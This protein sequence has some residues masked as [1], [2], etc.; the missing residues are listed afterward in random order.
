M[1]RLSAESSVGGQQ[2][3]VTRW[4]AGAQA[5]LC[6]QPRLKEIIALGNGHG[7]LQRGQVHAG[8]AQ[9]LAHSGGVGGG[10]HHHRVHLVARQRLGRAHAAQR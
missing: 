9:Q 10:D 6:Q 4:R 1:A 2:R 5:V 7:A 3:H 8:R